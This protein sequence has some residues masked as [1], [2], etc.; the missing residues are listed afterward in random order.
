M[1]IC[2]LQREYKDDTKIFHTKL[3]RVEYMCTHVVRVRDDVCFDQEIS[4][5]TPT[6]C[7]LLL[8]EQYF[9]A[10]VKNLRKKPKMT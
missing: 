7:Y 4:D 8:H 10:Q 3:T 1:Q 5:A 9:S 2:G 6:F